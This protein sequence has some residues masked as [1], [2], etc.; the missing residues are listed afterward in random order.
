MARRR[1]RPGEY[2]MADDYTGVNTYASR[3]SQ[4][5]WGSYARKPLARNVQE[6]ASPLGDPF[7][8]KVY[9]GPDYEATT[10][11][12]F[13]LSPIYIGKTTRPF[14]QNSAYAQAVNLSPGIGDMEIE[15]TFIIR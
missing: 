2:L 11:C 9:R 8:V 10:T 15:C 4:D 12:Q 14:P 3:L 5:F 7:P 1:G 6:I 13:E